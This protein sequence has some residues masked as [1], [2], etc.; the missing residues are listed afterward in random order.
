VIESGP[1]PAIH[2]VVRWRLA[3]LCQ[4]LWGEHHA[5]VSK[6]TLSRELRAMNYRK[7][8]ARPHHPAQADGAVDKGASTVHSVFVSIQPISSK[9]QDKAG[10]GKEFRR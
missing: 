5:T 8:F 2:G 3:D 1:T 7:L 10:P 4:W 9:K 6:Q